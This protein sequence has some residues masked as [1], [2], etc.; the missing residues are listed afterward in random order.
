MTG[1]SLLKEEPGFY[2][3]HHWI[4][5]YFIEVEEQDVLMSFL[6]KNDVPLNKV[7]HDLIKFI[8]ALGKA[9][10]QQ[11]LNLIVDAKLQITKSHNGT[12]NANNSTKQEPFKSRT[13]I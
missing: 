10:S 3:L 13:S 4:Y 2:V 1:H 12:C 7:T 6:T 11:D 9:N 8:N 5:E